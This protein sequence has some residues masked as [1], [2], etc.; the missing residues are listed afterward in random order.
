M[1]LYQG[2]MEGEKSKSPDLL[3][4]SANG[5]PQAEVIRH[6]GTVRETCRAA[7]AYAARGVERALAGALLRVS[8]R[9]ASWPG[10][11][12]FPETGRYIKQPVEAEDG[13]SC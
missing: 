11:T 8:V 3:C 2:G 1:S 5:A 12:E 13:I 7:F 6:P 9:P 10:R 4:E